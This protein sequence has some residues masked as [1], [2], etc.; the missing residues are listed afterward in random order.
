MIARVIAGVIGFLIGVLCAAWF[1]FAVTALYNGLGAAIVGH[2]LPVV[3]FGLI[4]G[5]YAALRT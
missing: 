1:V 4:V 3:G 2:P 5:L